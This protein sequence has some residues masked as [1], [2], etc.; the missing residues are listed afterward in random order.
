MCGACPY[1]PTRLC[2]F[3]DLDGDGVISAGDPAAPNLIPLPATPAFMRGFD[4]PQADPDPSLVL[5]QSVQVKY[6]RGDLYSL[7][8]VYTSN[9]SLNG[10]PP[11]GSC[12]TAGAGCPVSP[13]ND[14][15]GVADATSVTQRHN[16]GMFSAV[17]DKERPRQTQ[18]FPDDAFAAPSCPLGIP[19]GG[20]DPYSMDCGGMAH[21]NS[22]KGFPAA[23]PNG[24]LTPYVYPSAPPASPDDWPVVPFSREWLGTDYP[25][26]N[27]P[28]AAI[29][30]LLRFSS[31]IVSYDSAAPADRAYTLA[32]DAKEVV[33]TAPG[34]PIAGVL[35]DAYNYFVNSVFPTPPG[36]APDP[37]IDCRNFIIVYVTD[38]HDECSSDPCLGGSTGTGPAGDLGQVALPE[39]APGRR[40]AAN[41]LDPSVRV[42]G[43]PVFVV[44][45]NSDP[46]F[47]PALNCIATNSGGKL[48]AATDR[49]SL[50]G[51][52]E[53]ILDF[54]RN[55][56]FFASP[57]VPGFS[58]GLGDAVQVGAVIPS[59]LNVNGDLSSWAIWSGSLKSFQLDANGFLPVVTAAPGT[60]TTT[61]TSGGPTTTPPAGTPTPTPSIGAN[62]SLDESNPDDANPAA[63][64]PVWNAARVLGYTDPLASLAANAAPIPASPAARAPAISVWPGRK[65]VFARGT[66]GVPLTRADFMPNTGACAGA[67]TPGTCFDD[68]ML[69]MGLTPTSSAS[70]QTLARLTV[71]YLRGGVSSYGSRDEVLND[72]SVRPPTIG[73]IGPNAGEEQ[74]FSFF[75][76]DDAPAPGAPPQVRTDDDGSPPA[77]YPHKLGDIFHSEPLLLEPPQF[78]PY[79]A[80]DLTPGGPTTSYLDFAKLQ[81]K[82]RKVSFVGAN[83]GFLHAF[84]AGVYGRDTSNF[85]NAHD[86]G[87]GREIFAYSPRL[88]MNGKFPSLLNFPPLPQ[89]FVDGSMATADVFIDP[90]NDG[91]TPSVSDRVWRTVLVGS[92]RQGGRG[93]YALDVTQPDDIVTTTGPTF[94]EIAGNKDASPG[95]LNGAGASCSAGV[96]AS[97]KY[98]EILWEFTDGGADCS[99]NCTATAVA[100]ALGETWSRA[101]VG[102]IRIIT[103][104]GPPAAYEDRYVAIFGG[105]FD[106]SFTPGD[107]VA[108]KLP[109]G[110][111]FYIV[112]VETGKLLYKTTEGVAGD[113]G[114]GT[115]P[116]PVPFA[117]M[118]AAPGLID[119]DDDGYL[120]LAYMGDVNGN[121]WRIDLTPDPVSGRGV[122]GVTTPDQLSGYQPFLLYN[123]CGTALGTGPCTDQQP[124]FFEPAI[125]FM[126]GSINPPTLGVAFGT[127][128]R[129]ELARPNVQA[130]GFYDIIDSGQTA[131]TVVRAGS[132]TTTR[133]P[134]RDVTPVTG[135]GPC[136]SPFDPASC[137]NANGDRAPGF[138]LD[139]A[140]TNEKT[141]STVFSTLG[142]LSV[143]TFT[144]DSVSPCATN[145]SSYQYR[146]FFLT[147]SG[148]YGNTN[149]YADYRDSLGEGVVTRGQSIT[150]GSTGSGTHDMYFGQDRVDDIFTAGTVRTVIT[151]WK[152]QQ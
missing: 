107:N 134:V 102:R 121:M 108:A 75:Y 95:C 31:S 88:V 45:L 29:K 18:Q 109:K 6:V 112:D 60:P 34:T 30:R 123:G 111:A 81:A 141:T 113:G 82:R 48:F 41:A 114:S 104:P 74:K 152:E 84:D 94:G 70:N 71:Q 151:N 38:G 58:G 129:A 14:A 76:Q 68:L 57:S 92:L 140:T 17:Y 10:N 150:A 105:G 128:N 149:T 40:A 11:W 1:D 127:G 15:D 126:G 42:T 4:D 89:Y 77:G 135:L 115:P 9:D 91:V 143:V 117:P 59:H 103:D 99:D 46:A 97:R 5:I 122:L 43:I 116:A 35:L 138:V 62:T 72:P 93:Y 56:N 87:T 12:P 130:P 26:G 98:P 73:V 28:E 55:A 96:V 61:P 3:V 37:A 67:G 33:V 53:S 36:G 19:A 27:S 120:D 132:T 146:F 2:A 131:R 139:Y 24:L 8:P 125:I 51:A 110:R 25:G 118:P 63:R 47:F 147:G 64:K 148:P 100:P 137:V 83:D 145:G 124:I 7:P 136:P 144:P 54:K 133:I 13:D 86:L 49:T 50:Q 80:A 65:M 20:C 66:T 39:S 79:L 85:P 16:Q 106:P 90:A 23:A 21:F 32:E 119:Y 44:G 69:D 52:L 142:V 101:V 78:Y 22:F